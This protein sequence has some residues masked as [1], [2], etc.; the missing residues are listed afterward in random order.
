MWTVLSLVVST[1]ASDHMVLY[2]TGTEFLTN[3]SA[4]VACSHLLVCGLDMAIFTFIGPPFSGS[5]DV[6]H[7]WSF[8]II[9]SLSAPSS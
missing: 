1:L 3:F 7:E 9:C 4:I 2:L 6:V 5:R 8:S